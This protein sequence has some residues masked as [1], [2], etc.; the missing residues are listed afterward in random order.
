[1]HT[2]IHTYRQTDRHTYIHTYTHIHIHLSLYTYIY[3]YIYIYWSPRPQLE[4]QITKRLRGQVSHRSQ[5]VI[6]SNWRLTGVGYGTKC[7]YRCT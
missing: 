4:P 1:M 7:A 6:F 3:I 2:Y 5:S